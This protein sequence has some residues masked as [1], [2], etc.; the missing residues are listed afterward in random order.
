MA[1][2]DAKETT[3][4]QQQKDALKDIFATP[5][6][7]SQAT[8]QRTNFEKMLSAEPLADDVMAPPESLAA[9]PS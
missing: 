3:M 9:C 7:T 8:R 1:A 5:R 6:S 4:S 2:S